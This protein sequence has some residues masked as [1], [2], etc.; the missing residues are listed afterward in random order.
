MKTIN[1]NFEQ[2]K[3]QVLKTR[4]EEGVFSI[5]MNL[6]GMWQLSFT[7]QGDIFVLSDDDLGHAVNFES[8]ELVLNEIKKLGGLDF[9][10]QIDT[11]NL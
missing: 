2:L 6:V 1:Q 3:E 7:D 8:V 4:E 11:D 10:T 9:T 5:R